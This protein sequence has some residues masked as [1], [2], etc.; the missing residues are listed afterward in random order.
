MVT[1]DSRATA[2]AIAREVG[3][4]DEVYSADELRKKIA[5]NSFDCN[6]VAGVL[7]ED[8][9]LLVQSLQHGG[10]AVGMTG[11]GVNDAP[12]LKQAQVGIAVSN[13]TDVARAAASAV[14]TRP[15]LGDIVSAVQTGQQ[16]YQRM[17]TYTF[18][19]IIKTFQIAL[20]LSSGAL[21][22]GYLYHDPPPRGPTAIRQ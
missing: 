17:L 4:G 19:K 3:L 1:G 21:P 22:N 9:F 15:G 16:I 11:N 5:D 13:A 12:A 6:V 14:L 20:F 18:N 10:H 8:K 7:P 2:R